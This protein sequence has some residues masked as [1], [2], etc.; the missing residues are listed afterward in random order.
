[1][2]WFREENPSTPIVDSETL[3]KNIRG[4]HLVCLDCIAWGELDIEA[5]GFLVHHIV[6][7][8]QRYI[9]NNILLPSISG[10]KIKDAG[11]NFHSVNRRDVSDILC[12]IKILHRR[13]IIRRSVYPYRPHRKGMPYEYSGCVILS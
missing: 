12:A 5:N 8:P 11:F 10:A 7:L 4:H 9:D 13:P 6:Y 1:V 3:R 2:R